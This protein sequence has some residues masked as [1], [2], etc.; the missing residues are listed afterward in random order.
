[1]VEEER[2][3][4]HG[5]SPDDPACIRSAE[6]LE[7]YVI[8]TGFLPLFRNEIPGFSVEE[9]TASG[10]WWTGDPGRDP[11][12]WR[13]TLAANGNVCYGKFFDR[14]AG[15]I[16]KEWFPCFANYRR[17]G[18]DFDSRWDDE[19]AGIRS[20][21][22]M[23]L[24]ME[25]NEGSELFS[26]EVK[27]RAGFG[28]NREKNFE[29]ELTRLQMQTYLV[30]RDF[31][32][33]INKNGQEYGW[34]IAVLCTPEHLWGYDF[35]TSCYKE[36]PSDSAARIFERAAE[37]YPGVS[38]RSLKKVLGLRVPGERAEGPILSYPDNLIRALKTEELNAGELTEDQ[39][40]GLAVAVGQLKDKQKKVI[41][42]K[43]V[44]HMK[45]DEIGAALNRAAGTV[46]TYHSKALGKL[47]WPR[48][49]EWYLRGYSQCLPGL[50]VSRGF[51]ALASA[52]VA[53]ERDPDRPAD[54]EDLC[55]RLGLA[56]RI[57]DALLEAGI[58]T[59]GDLRKKVQDPKWYRDIRG[60]GSKTA[61]D[62]VKMLDHAENR[63]VF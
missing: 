24:F 38:L 30:N 43:Y 7:A 47:K 41:F 3:V 29:G 34:G 18:Y 57:S 40:S 39:K 12:E 63:Q 28:K 45:N 55:L 54:D 14:K 59:I 61:E 27:A 23:D 4:M 36:E 21:K 15:F 6:E 17:D 46:G 31:R 48:I 22:I 16:S 8:R 5:L 60:I 19:L 51:P 58:I 56:F 44:L 49:A 13:K 42:M 52:A 26:G 10:D 11:W 37:L 33:K 35:V 62:I 53:A 20:K 32:R 1:M 9:N 50:L 25:E 2:W